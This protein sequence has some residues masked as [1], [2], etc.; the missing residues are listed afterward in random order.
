[1]NGRRIE[2][3]A[4]GQVLILVAFGM[5][6]FLGITGLV[7]DI[8]AAYSEQRH[9]RSVAD[10]AALAGVQDVQRP[11][12][13]AVDNTEWTEGR[14]RAM[15]NLV[16][17]LN[18]GGSL[19]DCPA[20][21]GSAPY[22]AN[23]VNCRLGATPYYVSV[24]AP[25]PSCAT[26]GC[27]RDRSVQVT[28]RVPKFGLAFARL[29]PFNQLDWNVAATS[30]AELTYRASY[31]LVVLRP[32]KPSRANRPECSPDCDSNEDN[33]FIDGENTQLR[34]SGDLG[35]NT[36]ITLAQG[37][38]VV[39]PGRYGY[40]YDAYVNWTG[41][42]QP[43]RLSSPIE[44]PNYPI[45][46]QT[47][48]TPPA[49]FT[50][51][52]AARDTLG[53][54]TERALVQ[55]S[56]GIDPTWSTDDVRCYKPGIY[57]FKLVSEAQVKAMIL[58]PGVYF[59]NRGLD[60]GS[61]VILVGGYEPN[62]P[63]VALVFPSGTGCSP[64][65]AF[66]AQSA[67]LVA[68]NAGSAH[69]TIASGSPAT[70]AEHWTGTRI[71]TDGD[72]PVLMTIIV[73]KDPR[74]VVGTTEPTDCPSNTQLSLPGGGNIYLTGIQYAASDNST[75][76]GGSGTNGYIGQL[77]TW[78]VHF[79]GGSIVNLTHAGEEEPGIYRIATPCSPGADCTNPEARAAL[80]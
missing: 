45:P 41:D 18:P 64:P 39:P 65:C 30:V 36:N 71:Q 73:N 62:S 42:P 76:R 7:I 28:V 66:T 15:E 63:G 33:V 60:V 72:P 35:T 79:T 26:G 43:K 54:A 40:H 53:C 5:I 70:A 47:V 14:T 29:P 8:G 4:R 56:Y 59:F 21:G 44:D 1:M 67:G 52:A 17:Q 51:E 32:P 10:A 13:R 20:S 50:T 24:L 48:G 75:V 34:L 19:P 68:L 25:S 6:A 58:E 2:S 49:P 57:D 37:S 12:S 16:N 61:G 74:C 78:T 38:I 80:P 23:V 77:I 31:N 46:S 69:P 11:D 3:D 55:P 22:A 27:D 9:Q